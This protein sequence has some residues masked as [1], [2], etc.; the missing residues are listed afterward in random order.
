MNT[1][2]ASYRDLDDTALLKGFEEL[3]LPLESWVHRS[4]VRVAVLYLTRYGFDGGLDR[5]RKHI[6]A[7]NQAKGVKDSPSSGY[8]ETLTVAWFRVIA[9]ALEVMSRPPANSLEFCRQ[10]DFLLDKTLLRR[11]YTS[12]RMLTDEAKKKFIEPD[13]APLP[14]VLR[15]GAGIPALKK[16]AEKG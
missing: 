10:N 11:H 7:F 9:H 15:E 4:H 5:M 3:S 14:G 6:Q 8:H 12:E 1:T 13:L 2:P 16:P